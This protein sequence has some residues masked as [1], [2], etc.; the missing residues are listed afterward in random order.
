MNSFNP[1]D[2]EFLADPYPTYRRLR[3]EDPVHHSPLDFWVLTR[4]EDVVAVLRDPRFIKEPLVAFVA[5]RFGAAVPPG[6][7]GS[8]LDPDPPDHTRLRSLVSQ[9]FTPRVLDGLRP[10]IQEI[11]DS[12]ITPAQ[13]AGP[14]GL[15]QGPAHPPP[16]H[17]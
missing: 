16:G 13:A 12:L 14:M 11:V 15:I 5:A 4:Y 17:L 3:T 8:M 6:V 7:G 9:A 2:P 1:M 10:P